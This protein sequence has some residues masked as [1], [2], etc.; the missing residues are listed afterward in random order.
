MGI[1]IIKKQLEGF[2]VRIA[3]L[4]SQLANIERRV[5]DERRPESGVAIAVQAE[6]KR[7]TEDFERANVAASRRASLEAHR[8][9]ASLAVESRVGALSEHL[10]DVIDRLNSVESGIEHTGRTGVA[11]RL[12]FEQ[13]ESTVSALSPRLKLSDASQQQLQDERPHTKSSPDAVSRRGS[14]PPLSAAPAS[15]SAQPAS[16]RGPPPKQPSCIE[17][18]AE[19]S[20]LVPPLAE[21]KQALQTRIAAAA[22]SVAQRTSI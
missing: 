18:L 6:L 22:A 16:A 2:H 4:G 12:R 7:L 9:E 10:M 19:R 8:A 1:A 17:P 21:T 20:G 5:E 15:S 13:L 14:C 11:L 3:S